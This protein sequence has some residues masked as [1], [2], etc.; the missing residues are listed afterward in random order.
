MRETC[1]K[2]PLHAY[3]YPI[4]LFGIIIW[5]TLKEMWEYMLIIF[6]SFIFVAF[7]FSLSISNFFLGFIT[8]SSIAFFMVVWHELGHAVMAIHE[9]SGIINIYLKFDKKGLYVYPSIV[10]CKSD[11]DTLRSGKVVLG[12]V[13]ATLIFNPII[14]ILLYLILQRFLTAEL[15]PGIFLFCWIPFVILCEYFSSNESADLYKLKK[16][17]SSTFM[18]KRMLFL[19]KDVLYTMKVIV[20]YSLG[21]N[22]YFSEESLSKFTPIKTF[23]SGIWLGNQLIITLSKNEFNKLNSIPTLNG[24]PIENEAVNIW[25]SIN[26][27][28]TVQHIVDKFGPWSLDILANFRE[29]GLINL[30]YD[31]DKLRDS[32]VLGGNFNKFLPGKQ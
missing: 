23:N 8:Y 26:N 6:I 13:V 18:S 16:L 15:L 17:Y 2:I 5:Y 22:R 3:S 21:K 30:F 11:R 28:R 24:I 25:F 7:S 14:N 32:R 9:N 19:F 29:N 12:G 1:Y 20:C 10:Y 31:N 4:E 27:K